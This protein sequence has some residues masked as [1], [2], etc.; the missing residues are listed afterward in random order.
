MRINRRR[1]FGAV[2]V[3]FA[4]LAAACGSGEDARSEGS[5]IVVGSTN[6]T[7]QEIL[8]E[9][10]AQV[11]DAE[12][13]NVEKKFQLGARDVV[14]PAIESGDIGLYAEY[15]ATVLTFLSRPD[16]PAADITDV[17]AAHAELTDR[18]AV[19][20]VTVL[21]YSD[22][23][24]ANAIVVTQAMA[25]ELGLQKTSDLAPF[26]ADLVFGGPPECP[27]R[28]FCLIGLQDVYG[29][30]F[31][32]F[33]PLDVGGPITVAALE[34]GEID[35]GLLFSSDGAIAAKGFV[36]LDDDRQLQGADN[37]VPVLRSNLAEEFG[38]DLTTIINDVSA[39]ITTGELAVM[40]KRVNID[41]DDPSDVARDWL[42]ANGFIE[43]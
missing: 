18:F 40:N 13:F 1:V 5:T 22:A 30:D 14:E 17:D 19:R 42:V 28:E 26:A 21:D 11:L 23:I 7:E 33:K 38:N 16:S 41:K 32:E 34:G 31:K 4:L 25:D 6:F 29:L 2:L 36:V 8:G 3:S 15:V 12:G 24:D 39:K 35:V 27:E 9:I 10:Y 43:T 20:G 37:I